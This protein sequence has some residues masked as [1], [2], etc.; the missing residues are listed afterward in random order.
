MKYLILK[1][2]KKIK[3]VI[4]YL[5]NLDGL[6]QIRRRLNIFSADDE[7][8][9]EILDNKVSYRKENRQKAIF[10]EN[11]NL[12][13][14]FKTLN[15]SKDYYIND[16]SFLKF[17]KCS[18]LFDT[19]HGTIISIEDQ[20]LCRKLEEKFQLECYDD[21]NKHKVIV[22]PEPERLFDD[23]GVLNS[24]IR[25]YGIK[26]GLDISSTSS[27]LRL[28]L[29]NMSN[30]YSYLEY[31]YE[32][33]TNHHL[34]STKPYVHKK[35]SIKN[36]SIIVPVYNQDVT[37][38]LLSI[39]G[40]NLSKEDK[41]KLQV[42]VVDDGSKN[43]VIEEINKIRNKLDFELQI[44]SFEKNIGLSNARNV[45]FAIS[46]Y[47]QVVFIDSDIILS[48][49]Y[50]YDI[51]I[52]IQLIPNAIFT[53][54]RKNIDQESK[55]LN[56]NNLLLGIESS[57]N[58]DDSRVIT[59]GKAYHIGCDKAYINEELSVIDDTDYFKELSFGSQIGIYNIAT[60]VS[61]HNIALNKSL[62]K[63]ASPF[64]SK[65]KGWGMEDAY[66]SAKLISE[67]CYVIP[68]L[69]SCAYHIKHPPRSGSVEQK[70][71]EA[72]NNFN[73]YN[74]LLNRSWK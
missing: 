25:N 2:K 43:N 70:N 12:K 37:Y 34:L 59:K 3:S 52:R 33:V 61:G 39:Q 67:G 7:F 54:M 19:Y 44:I 21:I 5:I 31:Y 63:S 20:Q 66:F 9:I 27:S 8:Q 45:G 15:N 51:N 18:L 28:R 46:K 23:V 73:I 42:I 65:F 71:K 72:L 68:V 30:N 13:Y 17:K 29:S 26:T 22:K 24:K 6:P 50:I 10:I 1:N 14:F 41:Q 35:Y 58:F 11:K 49:N 38:T 69:S 55:I 36:M 40:Q 4:N 74:E 48:K 60:I 32:K 53:C 62:I 56:I 47:N 16:I 57:T 64:S